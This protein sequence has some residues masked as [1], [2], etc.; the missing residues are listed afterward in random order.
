MFGNLKTNHLTQSGHAALPY[1]MWS[2][3][4]THEFWNHLVYLVVAQMSGS[5]IMVKI[6]QDIQRIALQCILLLDVFL[7]KHEGNY[8]WSGS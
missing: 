2:D 3:Q 7:G 4:M 8:Q 1:H 5:I 6:Q